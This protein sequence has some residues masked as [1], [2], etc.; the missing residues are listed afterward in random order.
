[1]MMK[2]RIVRF[3]ALLG[4]LTLAGCATMPGECDVH[5]RNASLFTKIKC[6][7]AYEA[8]ADA[9]AVN[10]QQAQDENASVRQVIADLEAEQAVSKKSLQERQAAYDKSQ[11]SLNALLR[12][13]KARQNN[14]AG[15]QQQINALEQQ[16][17][18]SQQPTA[19]QSST[20]LAQR[21]KERDLLIQK[22]RALDASLGN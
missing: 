15:V 18:A 22:V 21:Q 10:L 8:Q 9:A 20:Q 12:N 16:L 1:M 19:S 6:T 13:V 4:S 7:N 3:L 11:A 2:M 14:K 5:D 17:A